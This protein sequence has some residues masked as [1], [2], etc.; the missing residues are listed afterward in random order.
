MRALVTEQ[1]SD[2]EFDRH[3][4]LIDGAG[5]GRDGLRDAGASDA[6]DTAIFQLVCTTGVTIMARD[7]AW[8]ANVR[9][10]T[11]VRNKGS[12]N[13]QVIACIMSSAAA[14]SSRYPELDR[15]ATDPTFPG[16]TSSMATLTLAPLKVGSRRTE[17]G[18]VGAN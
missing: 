2:D 14:S 16:G 18:I 3:W 13:S 4:H 15:I 12:S 6:K 1:S 7:G 17:G 5:V 9:S 10:A 11:I 8:K